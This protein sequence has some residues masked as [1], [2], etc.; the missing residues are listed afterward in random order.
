MMPIDR[1]NGQTI[2]HPITGLPIADSTTRG[3]SLTSAVNTASPPG[4]YT[5]GEDQ[6]SGFTLASLGISLPG[7][8]LP[9]PA[10][11]RTEDSP[12]KK[13]GAAMYDMREPEWLV[14]G[15]L[16]KSTLVILAGLPKM[17]R[18]TT[19]AQYISLCLARGEPLFG[20][21]TKQCRVAVLNLEDGYQRILR[22][23]RAFGILPDDP[24]EIYVLAEDGEFYRA[25]ERVKVFRPDVLIIDPLM[26]VE[27]A[28][29]VKNENDATQMGGVMRA[30]RSLTRNCDMLSILLHHFGTKNDRA[31][32]S[33]TLQGS[34]DGWFDI[35][36]LAKKGCHR[37][38]WWLRDAMEGHVDLNIKFGGRGDSGGGVSVSV[39]I[40]SA[41]VFGDTGESSGKDDEEK[42]SVDLQK[43]LAV[44]KVFQS[45]K[46][47]LSRDM[48]QRESGIK[49]ATVSE[50]MNQ[51]KADNC[52]KKSGQRWVW[53]GPDPSTA[54]GVD[55]VELSAT[56][57][58]FEA[59]E[60]AEEDV[61]GDDDG[62]D[63]D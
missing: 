23:Y 16:A 43:Y 45:A 52:I 4:G 53:A 50:I 30:L 36:F 58:A 47:P 57:R 37:L 56:E 21:P 51:L 2:I 18:K 54:A 5:I 20:L 38:S 8:V 42:S 1:S 41:P 35:R 26:E 7:G 59:R 55:F 6:F 24:A 29:G 31:R 33:S 39:D 32:G 60:A 14:E 46:E 62:V 3:S 27:L 13:L 48:V 10:P 25:I 34:T 28:M 22:R 12:F 49:T 19:L 15:L 44:V 11:E 61:A 63:V 40:E 17:G 9:G